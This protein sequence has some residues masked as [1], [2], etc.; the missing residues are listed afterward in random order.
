MKRVKHVLKLTVT[1]EDN[2]DFH[3]L[4]E[5]L[6]AKVHDPGLTAASAVRFAIRFALMNLDIANEEDITDCCL[7][8]GPQPG[9]PRPKSY[10]KPKHRQNPPSE[11]VRPITHEPEDRIPGEIAFRCYDC[12]RAFSDDESYLQHRPCT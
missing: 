12:G 1:A 5:L 4:K 2:A 8:R 3:R 11:P 9:T 7:R 6:R 10:G